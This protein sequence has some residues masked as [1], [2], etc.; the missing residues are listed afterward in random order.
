MMAERRL[1]SGSLGLAIITNMI[2]VAVSALVSFVI[3]KYL[4]ETAGS[5]TYSYYPI[6]TNFANYFGLIFIAVNAMSSRFV[7]VA[8]LEGNDREAREYYSSIFFADLLLSGL[9]TLVLALFVFN[10][11]HILD[12][13]AGIVPQV[14]Q[15]FVWILLTVVVNGLAAVFGISIYARNRMDIKAVI[16]LVISLSK[17]ILFLYFMKTGKLTI[18]SYGFVLFVAA[19]VHF[20]LFVAATRFL[21]PDFHFSTELFSF[22][23]VKNLVRSGFWVMVNQLG[24]MMINNAQLIISNIFLGAETSAPLSLVQTLYQF[25]SLFF[26]AIETVLQPLIV[27]ILVT[28][29][30]DVSEKMLY[31]QEIV[32]LFVIIPCTLMMGFGGSF[33]HLWLPG[34]DHTVL[35]VLSWLNMSQL[36][37]VYMSTVYTSSMTALNKVKVPSIAMIITG[38]F[39]LFLIFLVLRFTSLGTTGILLANNITY[40]LF[41]VVFL[42][43]YAGKQ[44]EGIRTHLPVLVIMAVLFS[45]LNSLAGRYLIPSGYITLF[46]Y[47]IALEILGCAIVLIL[48]R[49]RPGKLLK[50]FAER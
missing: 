36:L 29:S 2:S 24:L 8:L 20:L 40:I 4:I 5:V 25:G 6:A 17:L 48:T 43:Y 35:H 7:M 10:I 34:E 33:Y 49:T 38:C 31:L 15:L 44:M 23:K 16:D 21:L 26:Y 14:R 50:F 3:S 19:V 13:P 22:L 45:A 46:A 32:V 41:Y 1:K 11:E 9:V 28:R 18:V 39:G 12:I 30:D 47:C 42:P 27:K 37:L